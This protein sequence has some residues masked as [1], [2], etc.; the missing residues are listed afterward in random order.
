MDFKIG[1]IPQDETPVFDE[2]GDAFPQT[3]S[4][5][6][7]C[8]V[9]GEPLPDVTGRGRKPTMHDECRNKAKSA[10]TPSGSLRGS[11]A[12]V[13][14]AMN[15]MDTIYQGLILVSNLLAPTVARGMTERLPQAQMLNRKAFEMDRKLARKVASMGTPGGMTAFLLAQGIMVSPILLEIKNRPRKDKPP[16]IARPDNRPAPETMPADPFE[17]RL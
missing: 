11:N 17:G 3:D 8:K 2:A 13:T 4:A 7:L 10:S 6:R 5:T 1:A 16:R 15:T 12:D 9:C 14:K